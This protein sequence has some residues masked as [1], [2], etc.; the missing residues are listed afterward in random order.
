[1]KPKPIAENVTSINFLF[2]SNH[3]Q[4]SQKHIDIFFLILAL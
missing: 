1:M 4:F 3:F 2:H